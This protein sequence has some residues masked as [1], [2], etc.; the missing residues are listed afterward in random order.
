MLQEKLD[1][2][3]TNNREDTHTEVRDYLWRFSWRDN[4]YYFFLISYER[5][6][7]FFFNPTGYFDAQQFVL[8]GF[9]QK[10]VCVGEVQRQDAA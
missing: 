1:W 9:Q 6:K 5:N 7:E 2:S 10:T 4:Q 8:L 3:K